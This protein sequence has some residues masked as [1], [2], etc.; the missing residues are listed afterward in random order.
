MRLD[1][2]FITAQVAALRLMYPELAEDE[3]AWEL[4]V[5]SETDVHELLRK[6]ERKRR[7]AEIFIDAIETNI[8]ELCLRQ[9]R[10]KRREKAMR[11]LAMRILNAADLRRAELPEA[12]LSIASGR[13]RLIITDEDALPDGTYGL[14]RIPNKIR[15]TELLKLGAEVR[16][17]VLS[18]S[19]PHLTIRTR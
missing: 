10:F 8:N 4:S 5:E 13:P 9:D 3:E 17:A 14:R 19:E 6:V 15:I 7:E 2:H 16:G 11:D 18:N 12:T 1:P